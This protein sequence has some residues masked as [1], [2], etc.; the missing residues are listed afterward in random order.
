[1]S[2]R[3]ESLA[4]APIGDVSRCP[5]TAAMKWFALVVTF[6][7]GALTVP[8]IM[9][10]EADLPPCHMVVLI[11][12]SGAWTVWLFRRDRRRAD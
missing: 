3:V 4:N 1:M 7:L 2:A 10:A 6:A 5:Y 12:A 11:G 8:Q 9:P